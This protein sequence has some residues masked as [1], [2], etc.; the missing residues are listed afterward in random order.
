MVELR[1][2]YP[3]NFLRPK[4]HNVGGQTQGKMNIK[5]HISLWPKPALHKLKLFWILFHYVPWQRDG[6]TLRRSII[7]TRSYKA[8]FLADYITVHYATYTSLP[9]KMGHYQYEV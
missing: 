7:T 5:A 3:L 4:Y 6:L 9:S 1:A 8:K 2:K